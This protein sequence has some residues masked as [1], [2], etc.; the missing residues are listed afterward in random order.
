M[1]KY[2]S[3][4]QFSGNL[5]KFHNLNSQKESIKEKKATVY[6]NVSE[7]YNEHLETYS[8]EYKTTLSDAKKEL[9]NIYNP[10]NL[11]FETYNYDVWF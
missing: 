3:F 9:G 10:I 1:S 11:F 8:D 7:L 2:P 4:L 6:D 5:N